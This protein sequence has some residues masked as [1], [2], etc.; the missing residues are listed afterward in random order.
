MSEIASI[1]A[2][3]ASRLRDL[4]RILAFTVLR[5]TGL[6][7]T[8][9]VG[10]YLTILIAN[11]GGQVDELRIVQIRSTIA[12]AAR[13]NRATAPAAFRPTR[14]TASS[15]TTPPRAAITA[16][17]IYPRSSWSREAW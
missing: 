16:T 13:A 2:P 11:M 1:S 7:V 17:S 6:F 5:L 12:E 10:V 15:S 4:R 3:P 8:V 9:I 14:A